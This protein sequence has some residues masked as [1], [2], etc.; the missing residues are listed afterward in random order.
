MPNIGELRK[1]MLEEHIMHLFHSSRSKQDGSRFE[2]IVLMRWYE[3]WCSRL[4]FSMSNLLTSE[5]RTSKAHNTSSKY[6]DPEME[7]GEYYSGF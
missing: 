1:L 7:M 2:T 4:C 3:E 5:S 6:R